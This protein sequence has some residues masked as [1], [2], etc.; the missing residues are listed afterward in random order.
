M[1]LHP[2]ILL[3]AGLLTTGCAS[4]NINPPTAKPNTGYVDFFVEERDDLHWQVKDVSRNQK[5]FYEFEPIEGGVLRLALAPGRHTLQVRFLNLV[6]LD[7]QANAI[8]VR[9]GMITPVLVTLEDAGTVHVR[10]KE[11]QWTASYSG[12]RGRVTKITTPESD[13]Y[14]VVLQPAAP[15]PYKMKNEMPYAKALN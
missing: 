14:R 7:P 13:A 3:M 11:E 8:E 9:D 1:R 12:R 2:S 10:E 6:V 15:V 4:S 5:L